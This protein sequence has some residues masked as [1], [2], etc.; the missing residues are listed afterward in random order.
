[1]ATASSSDS[2]GADLDRWI[3][4]M[5]EGV[6][7]GIEAAR[8]RIGRISRQFGQ[9]L[10]RAAARHELSVGDW[11][12]LS[13]LRRSGPPYVRT[14]KQ[15]AETLGITSGTV[16]VRID[17]L[18]RAG[19]AEPVSSADGRSRPVGLTRKGRQR[20]SAATKERTSYE[21]RI[22]SGALTSEQLAELN[23]LL[24]ALLARFEEEFGPA[25]RHDVNRSTT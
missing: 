13:V 14:P 8:Q 16:S 20:W 2:V 12:A 17:R 18:I 19:L 9:V 3:A 6:D 24:T 11:E 10:A 5:P 22:F 7:P 21:Q 23:P 25:S 15:L 1:M 4:Q